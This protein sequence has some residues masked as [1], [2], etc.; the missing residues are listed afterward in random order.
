MYNTDQIIETI[1]VHTTNVSIQSTHTEKNM[2]ES[3]P[4]DT[5][6]E[7]DTPR[8]A[9]TPLEAYVLEHQ[10]VSV[11]RNPNYFVVLATVMVVMSGLIAMLSLPVGL[12][13]LLV[14]GVFLWWESQGKDHTLRRI[15]LKTPTYS[16][17]VWHKDSARY[18][19]SIETSTPMDKTL[20]VIFRLP[21]IDPSISLRKS[22]LVAIMGIITISTVALGMIEIAIGL[23]ALLVAMVV[24]ALMSS[25]NIP[26][27]S[28]EID[29]M[30]TTVRAYPHTAIAYLPWESNFQQNSIDSLE[31]FFHGFAWYIQK[32]EK[33]CV[34]WPADRPYPNIQPTHQTM[35]EVHTYTENIAEIL[36]KTHQENHVFF[37]N[38]AKEQS[39]I[40]N[41]GIHDGTNNGIDETNPKEKQTDPPPTNEDSTASLTIDMENPPQQDSS[42]ST[43][44]M[45]STFSTTQ[46][47]EPS[48]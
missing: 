11:L 9:G 25:S 37:A 12:G 5:P 2:A 26:D 23:V 39:T 6:L 45:R 32:Y 42:T 24:W 15:P 8:E 48:V 43:E 36:E 34:L 18:R 14:Y 13:I 46:N 16:K 44:A 22:Q 33:I 19:Y 35:W 1:T 47:N 38:R 28:R 17:I 40:M 41:N 3:I 7:A 31:A 30:H 21:L 4:S 27:T 10:P 20:Y 29:N